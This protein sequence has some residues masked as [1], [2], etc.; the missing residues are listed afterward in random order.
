M[1]VVKNI[2]G[3]SKGDFIVKW[4]DYNNKVHTKIFKNS[5]GYAAGEAEIKAN[6]FVRKLYNDG[7]N[8]RSFRIFSR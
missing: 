6:K 3:K 4:T 8:V 7:D 5:P 1:D 2:I